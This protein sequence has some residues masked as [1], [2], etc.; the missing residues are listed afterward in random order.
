MWVQYQRT[1]V[2]VGFMHG[3][4]AV[5]KIVPR[6]VLLDKIDFGI[7]WGRGVGV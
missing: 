3:R 6:E 5:W 4:N 2:R 1:R 7:A